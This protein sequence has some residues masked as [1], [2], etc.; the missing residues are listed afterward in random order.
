MVAN[1]TK[2]TVLASH[3]KIA[4]TLLSRSIGLLGQWSLE[5][6]KALL[7]RRCS[8]IH[9]FFMFFN[10]DVVFL[11]AEN[12]V[13]K[14]VRNLSPFRI[15]WGPGGTLSVLELPTGVIKRSQTE[16]GDLLSFGGNFKGTPH[17]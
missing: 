4:D 15:A 3:L 1:K 17:L 13:T 10:I 14:T 11:D 7:I 12:R 5:K 8:S 6:E 9:T 2:G 16:V